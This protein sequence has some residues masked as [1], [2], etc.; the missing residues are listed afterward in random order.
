M[1]DKKGNASIIN[2]TGLG[3]TCMNATAKLEKMLG[4]VDESSRALTD[5]FFMAEP[6][7]LENEIQNQ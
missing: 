3:M 1:I 6:I 4:I 5:N 2:V 7:A